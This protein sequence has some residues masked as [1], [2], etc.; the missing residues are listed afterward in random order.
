M[1]G[2][3]TSLPE[4]LNFVRV[5]DAFYDEVHTLR[6]RIE[7]SRRSDDPTLSP[8]T[9]RSR[10]QRFLEEKSSEFGR[11]SES[12]EYQQFRQVLYVLAALSDEIFLSFEW[13]GRDDWG[14]NLI[15][16]ALFDSHDAGVRFFDLLDELLEARDSAQRSVAVIYM[17]A[18]AMGFKGK[19]YGTDRCEETIANYRLRLYNFIYGTRPGR[20][21]EG[22]PLTPQAHWYNVSGAAERFPSVARWFLLGTLAIVVVLLGSHGAWVYGTSDINAVLTEFGTAP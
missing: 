17:L 11:H 16:K 22:T 2:S 10:V 20:R 1:S 3:P 7:G 8:E 15:E 12:F 5:F 21:L 14:E 19:Q 18:L 13:P 9:V 6:T 4:E